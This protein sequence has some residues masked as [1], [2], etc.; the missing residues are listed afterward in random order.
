M[1]P[2]VGYFSLY[3]SK[4]QLQFLAQIENIGSESSGVALEVIKDIWLQYNGEPLK[5]YILS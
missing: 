2:R 4:V 5:W 3:L 1:L